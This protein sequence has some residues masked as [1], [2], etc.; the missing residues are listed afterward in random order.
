MELSER[1][2]Y[3]ISKYSSLEGWIFVKTIECTYAEALCEA[4]KLQEKDPDYQYRV[5][6]D[7]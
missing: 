2:E 6:D 4:S 5:Y 3:P 1:K 7:R